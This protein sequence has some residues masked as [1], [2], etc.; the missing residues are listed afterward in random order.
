[1][2]GCSGLDEGVAGA[3][4]GRVVQG[5][6]IAFEGTEE[7]DATLVHEA[8]IESRGVVAVDIE[9]ASALCAA[10][11]DQGAVT[12]DVAED[13]QVRCTGIES[14]LSVL[15]HGQRTH[16]HVVAVGDIDGENR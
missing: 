5:N 1:M 11:S 14:D 3:G 4:I 8:A 13:G 10:A 15:H 7:G 16:F 2:D 9:V 6:H 12:A